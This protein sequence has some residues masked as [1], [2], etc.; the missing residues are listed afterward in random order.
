MLD[1]KEIYYINCCSSD[2]ELT[3][4]LTKYQTKAPN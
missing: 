4:C 3:N 2:K 1:K